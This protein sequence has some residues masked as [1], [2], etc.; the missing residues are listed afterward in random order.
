MSSARRPS[1]SPLT[2]AAEAAAEAAEAAEGESSHLLSPSKNPTDV[3]MP[4][5]A[6]KDSHTG[7][8]TT[9]TTDLIV[10]ELNQLTL[11]EREQVYEDVHGVSAWADETP[12][13]LAK[14]LA[15]LAT[16]LTNLCANHNNSSSTDAYEQAL[17]KSPSYVHNPKF[18]LMFLRADCWD[19]ARAAIRVTKF[20]RFKLELFDPSLLT[21]DITLADLNDDDKAAIKS[22]RI[23]LLPTR[24]T[25]GR[26][27]LVDLL[28][29][30][31]QCV[32]PVN[33][34]VCIFVMFGL[35]RIRFR[36][37]ISHCITSCSLHCS[38]K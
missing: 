20:F 33:S 35:F 17:H 6:D 5:A 23:Q 13:F 38:S 36:M 18:L 11:H 8:D 30:H 12:A 15:E 3:M 24:D 16:E 22:G 25:G 27:V 9:D 4:A 32:K 14:S 19:A 37:C 1:F 28:V 31:K 10:K 7:T 2:A 26:A 29:F 34:M 21:K